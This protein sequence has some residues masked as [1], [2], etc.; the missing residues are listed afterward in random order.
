MNEL[1]QQEQMER[2][3]FVKEIRNKAVPQKLPEPPLYSSTSLQQGAVQQRG[4]DMVSFTT[5]QA[6]EQRLQQ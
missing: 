6:N 3:R 5:D 1:I 2:Q 4:G